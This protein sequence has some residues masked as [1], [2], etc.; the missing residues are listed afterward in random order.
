MKKGLLSVL[1]S[2]LVVST[3][4]AQ[5]PQIIPKPVSLKTYHGHFKLTAK[6][7][8]I[9]PAGNDELRKLGAL[10]AGELQTPVGYG[11]LVSPVNKTTGVIRLKLNKTANPVIGDEGYH[12]KVTATGVTISA[13]QP[14]GLFYGIQTLMQL[15][16]PDVESAQKVSGV[17]W[18]IPAVDITDYPRFGWRGLMLDVSR[19]FFFERGG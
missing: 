17:N 5:S 2:I 15:L 13:N 19:H 10:L 6:T 7:R 18:S 11:F 14:A 4:L 8:I 9:I 16:P 12:L 3:T 1:I